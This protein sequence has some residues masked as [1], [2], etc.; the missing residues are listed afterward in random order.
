MVTYPISVSLILS[1]QVAVHGGRMHCEPIQTAHGLTWVPGAKATRPY[2]SA[3]GKHPPYKVEN[4]QQHQQWEKQQS[5]HKAP[6]LAS[7]IL[8]RF[9]L[10]SWASGKQGKISM[11]FCEKGWETLLAK[12]EIPRC[13][14]QFLLPAFLGVNKGFGLSTMLLVIDGPD[15]L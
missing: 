2:P 4:H 8:K 11:Y 10:R 3:T 6:V 14:L 5:L 12:L 15:F 1:R 7:T 9:M 13:I